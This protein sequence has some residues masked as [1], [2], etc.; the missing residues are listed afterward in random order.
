[1]PTIGEITELLTSKFGPARPA[2]WPTLVWD[3]PDGGLVMYFDCRRVIRYYPDGEKTDWLD[4]FGIDRLNN[5]L[6]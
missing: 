6:A 4:S 3:H 5:L 1:M 2:R